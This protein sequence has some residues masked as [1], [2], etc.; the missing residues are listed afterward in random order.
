MN[1]VVVE[2][3][4]PRGL[5]WVEAPTSERFRFHCTQ[6]ADG[7]R[8]IAVGTTVSFEP[9]PWHLGEMEATDIKVVG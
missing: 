2:F 9:R 3:D 5:G 8:T 4:D 7:S 6:L 1:G